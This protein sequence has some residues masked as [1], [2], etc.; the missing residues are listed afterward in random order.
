MENIEN[1]V[2][3][4]QSL[5]KA[6]DVDKL[7]TNC[8]APDAMI[9]GEGAPGIATGATVI[10]DVLIYVI[11]QTPN[12]TISATEI[13]EHSDTVV[14]T[15]LQWSNPSEE[16][17]IEFRSLAVWKKIDGQWKIA[18]DMYGIGRFEA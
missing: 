9:C 17:P 6:G 10:R 2:N 12:L 8:F 16:G 3:T 11:E 13:Q 5:F 18:S 14:S 7:Q 15:W 1:A 4:L